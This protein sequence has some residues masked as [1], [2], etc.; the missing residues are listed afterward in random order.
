ME[1]KN[2]AITPQLVGKLPAG[3]K[4]KKVSL[5]PEEVLVTMP[6]TKNDRDSFKILT[7]PIY[8]DAITTDSRIFCGIIARPSIQPV[9][10]SWP[11]VEVLVEVEAKAQVESSKN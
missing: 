9:A 2:L 5:Q 11:D 10:K 6:K 7:T 8:L 4:L 1:E 3:L